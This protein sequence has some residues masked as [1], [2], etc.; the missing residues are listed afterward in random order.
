MEL[1]VATFAVVELRKF[2]QEARKWKT[3]T[4]S[5]FHSWSQVGRSGIEGTEE[6]MRVW[7]G[8]K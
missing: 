8:F 4:E 3:A 1:V 5:D 7:R 6:G 2:S